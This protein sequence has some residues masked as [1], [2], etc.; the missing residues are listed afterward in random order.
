MNKQSYPHKKVRVISS[1]S[2]K[3]KKLAIVIP[4]Y[5]NPTSLEKLSVEVLVSA[6]PDIPCIIVVPEGLD[7]DQGAFCG[8]QFEIATFENHNF[9]SVKT[10]AELLTSRSFYERFIGYDYILIYQLDCLLFNKNFE[11]FIE[12]F[13]YCA[14]PIEAALNGGWPKTDTVGCGGFSLRCTSASLETLDYL[15][16]LND[17]KEIKAEIAKFGSEDVFWGQTAPQI[18]PLFRVPDVIKALNFGMNGAP[19]YLKRLH[20][21][22]EIVGCHAWH[23][24][25]SVWFY[26]KW[27]P[28]RGFTKFKWIVRA[29][30][31]TTLVGFKNVVRRVGRFLPWGV[32]HRS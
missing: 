18:N 25:G 17:H 10:Y 26:R 14:P 12:K 23:T 9:L 21:S 30:L 2:G 11:R 1:H 28:L 16:D 20:S 3:P 5:R 4:I 19:T 32:W 15:K 8:L 22:A 24:P 7:L 27:L 29:L 13:D 31:L 6:A